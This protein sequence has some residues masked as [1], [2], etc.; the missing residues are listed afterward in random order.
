MNIVTRPLDDL[1]DE[2]I[3]NVIALVAYLDAIGGEMT[4]I[5][6]AP[7]TTTAT[8][9]WN[10]GLVSATFNVDGELILMEISR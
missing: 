4:F 1:P 3:A 8:D 6:G 5:H 2:R 9:A 7:S 10:A